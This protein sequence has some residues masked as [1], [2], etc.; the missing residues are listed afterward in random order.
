MSN[1]GYATPLVAAGSSDSLATQKEPIVNI[2]DPTHSSRP[3]SSL[4]ISKSF[5]INNSEPGPSSFREDATGVSAKLDMILKKVTSL[6]AARETSAQNFNFID[7]F[8]ILSSINKIVDDNRTLKEEVK[9]KQGKI[10]NLSEKLAELALA[11]KSKISDG[12]NEELHAKNQKLSEELEESQVQCC[13]MDEEII[14]LNLKISSLDGQRQEKHRE[15]EELRSRITSL[16]ALLKT[17]EYEIGNK[18]KAELATRRSIESNL[19]ETKLLADTA[20][21]S[22]DKLATHVVEVHRKHS[23]EIQKTREECNDKIKKIMNQVYK[24]LSRS[25][26]P[27]IQYSGDSIKVILKECVREVTLT[28]VDTG[29]KSCS[30]SS[31]I[32]HAPKKETKILPGTS[33]SELKA[34]EFKSAIPEPTKT[35]NNHQDAKRSTEGLS[36]IIS[37]P[38]VSGL[39]ESS[40]SYIGSS[41]NEANE[42]PSSYALTT[43]VGGPKTATPD[44][45]RTVS[46]H[47]GLRK[48][49][50]RSSKVIAQPIISEAYGSDPE[51][52]EEE[53][54][55]IPPVKRNDGSEPISPPTQQ[56]MFG[57]G[58]SHVRTPEILPEPSLPV[59]VKKPLE[60]Y[61]GS[62]V[63]HKKD[64][65]SETSPDISAV[66]PTVEKNTEQTV[67]VH[68]PIA[69]DDSS[70]VDKSTEL[71]EAINVKI[72]EGVREYTPE[73][74]PPPEFVID[75]DS[76]SDWLE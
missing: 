34:N 5:P 36:K 75:S 38:V 45:K 22:R 55:D 21:N 4:Q 25:F 49:T 11:L 31:D 57:D 10:E 28:Y 69:P 58:L 15:T 24:K 65:V 48:S 27:N 47:Q 26:Q 33:T 37:Q 70:S 3:S 66:S 67:V 12:G 29:E 41:K 20:M 56:S 16:E 74:P 23:L 63:L 14:A 62:P 44:P 43:N 53:S 61:S 52:V 6:D 76:E 51:V 59:V 42:L 73:P 2:I 64:I 40:S 50:E 7:P 68:S 46:T 39:S 32:S 1:I 35:I 71:R 8:I 30:S 18:L 54:Y 17:K 13:R 9:E 19:K 60:R 72:A